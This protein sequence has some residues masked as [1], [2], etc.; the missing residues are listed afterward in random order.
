MR[1]RTVIISMAVLWS[2][3]F[4]SLVVVFFIWARDPRSQLG[5]TLLEITSWLLLAVSIILIPLPFIVFITRRKVG[6]YQA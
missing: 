4:L 6:V 2:I 1:L 5:G 3:V